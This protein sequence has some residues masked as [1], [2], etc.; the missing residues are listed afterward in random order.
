MDFESLMYGYRFGSRAVFTEPQQT[1]LGI[2]GNMLSRSVGSS[3]EFMEHREYLPGDDLRRIDWGVY[4]RSDRLAVKLF[5]EEVNPHVDVLLDVSRSMNLSGTKKGE[6]TYALTGF[7]ASAAAESRFSF[8][9]F[10]TDNGCRILERSH[11]MPLDWEP[12]D[13]ATTSSPDD[14]FRQMQPDWR[15]RGIRIFVSD[16]LFMADPELIVSRITGDAAVTIL[17]QLLAQ[18][19]IEPPEQGNFRLADCETG[20]RLEV[21]LDMLSREQYKR[22]L[23]RHQENYHLA[24]RRH[25]A[26]LTTVIA[27]HFLETGRL[28]ELF[29][30]ELL[31]FNESS[32]RF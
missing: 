12:F 19:D 11:L 17:V 1:S 30:L 18:S 26:Y 5:R 16:F 28:D 2:M 29:H 6:A 13:L 8:R 10:V 14:A 24:A 3:L 25:G 21:Y 23:A 7:L 20:E 15:P 4:A 32:L 31:K 22:N 27:E 9:V